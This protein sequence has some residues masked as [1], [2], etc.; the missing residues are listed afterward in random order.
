MRKRVNFVSNVKKETEYRK[1]CKINVESKFSI[2][3]DSKF[4][5]SSFLHRVH[6]HFT[7][8]QF[9]TND[10]NKYKIQQVMFLV[11]T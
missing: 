6:E 3:F 10:F 9:F 7:R 2:H 5:D 11:N 8:N 4:M 1:F